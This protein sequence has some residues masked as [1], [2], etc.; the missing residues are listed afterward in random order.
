LVDIIFDW[1]EAMPILAFLKRVW[2]HY[3]IYRGY[4]LEPL[5]AA[6]NAWRVAR[7]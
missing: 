1:E 2:L 7:R 3:S 6:K 5:P 4:P